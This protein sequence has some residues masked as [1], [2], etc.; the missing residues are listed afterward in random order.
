MRTKR[1]KKQNSTNTREVKPFTLELKPFIPGTNTQKYVT[2]AYDRGSNLVLQGPAGTGKS[3]LSLALALQDILSESSPY[4]KLYIVRS[5]VPTRDMGFLPGS[6]RDK[7]KVYEGPYQ[8]ICQA[9]FDSSMAYEQLK[10]RGTIQFVSTSFLRGHTFNDSILLVD[11][12]QN[13]TFHELDSVITRAGTNSRLIF[14]GDKDQ[15]DFTVPTDK[16][17]LSKFLHILAHMK[18]FETFTFTEHDILRSALVREYITTKTRL[19]TVY[20]SPQVL[21]S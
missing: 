3:F 19:F 9:L 18:S 12:M 5:V 17:G 6:I 11:E 20:T 10:Q 4:K 14:T 13:A 21:F 2:A 1:K 7:I 8:E 15:T 16:D